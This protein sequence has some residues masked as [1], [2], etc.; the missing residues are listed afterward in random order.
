MLRVL[1]VSCEMSASVIK[2]DAISLH[3]RRDI[4]SQGVRV[5]AQFCCCLTLI[6]SFL[7]KLGE[8]KTGCR[9]EVPSVTSVSFVPNTSESSGVKV[10]VDTKGWL[11]ATLNFWY[12][13]VLRPLFDQ[14]KGIIFLFLK[15]LNI[16]KY[17]FARSVKQCLSPAPSFNTRFL[18]ERKTDVLLGES[19]GLLRTPVSRSKC[20][21]L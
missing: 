20:R 21:F 15:I 10:S 13:L 8:Q 12:R 14:M 1:P 9:G 18:G 4:A 19:D 3:A 7:R 2:S 16:F 11:K 17:I 6:I 5:A